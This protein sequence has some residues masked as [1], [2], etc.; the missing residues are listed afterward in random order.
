MILGAVRND[1]GPRGDPR[2]VSERGS[3]PRARHTLTLA[4]RDRGRTPTSSG[5]GARA[6]V[7]KT[8]EQTSTGTIRSTAGM[9][10][11]SP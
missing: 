7:M 9:G 10:S 5:R 4:A 8:F 6:L 3:F 1:E 11:A 2:Y